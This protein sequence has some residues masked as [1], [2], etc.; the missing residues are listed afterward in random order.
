MVG[1][2]LGVAILGILFGARIEETAR[3]PGRF[4]EALRAAFLI[5][6]AAQLCGAVIALIC[7]HRGALEG[8]QGRPG[9]AP[10]ASPRADWS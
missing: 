4:L 9:A 8:R 6:G 5:G 10:D 7:F 2:T 3:D 1:A